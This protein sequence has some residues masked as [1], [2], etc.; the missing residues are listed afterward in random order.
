MDLKQALLDAIHDDPVRVRQVFADES[1]VSAL[2]SIGV[3]HKTGIQLF[4]LHAPSEAARKAMGF[5]AT[6]CGRDGM[7][8][9]VVTCKDC[10]KMRRRS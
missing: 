7:R 6:L 5:G 2:A 9:H 4:Q 10:E 3:G 8:H 1:V